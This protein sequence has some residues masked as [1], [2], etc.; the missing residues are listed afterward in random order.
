MPHETTGVSNM[1]PDRKPLGK[2][3]SKNNG[4]YPPKM[5]EVLWR[6][7]RLLGREWNPSLLACLGTSGRAQAPS[8][9]PNRSMGPALLI[10]LAS[11][12]DTLHLV[13]IHNYH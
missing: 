4:T 12:D 10:M 2:E 13:R 6:F 7:L 9:D 11:L 5:S 8:D 3:A 1:V